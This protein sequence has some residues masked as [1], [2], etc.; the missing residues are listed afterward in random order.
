MPLGAEMVTGQA[1]TQEDC[2]CAGTSPTNH[3]RVAHVVGV[4]LKVVL[5]LHLLLQGLIVGLVLLSFL[6]HA[7]NVVLGETALQSAVSTSCR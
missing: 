5:G 3:S 7:L 2:V 4:V 6:H 1:G